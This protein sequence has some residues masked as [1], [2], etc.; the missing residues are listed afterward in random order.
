MFIE[1]K[2]FPEKK[3]MPTKLFKNNIIVKLPIIEEDEEDLDLITPEEGDDN[4][5]VEVVMLGP[6]CASKLEIGDNVIMRVRSFQDPKTGYIIGDDAY[7]MFSEADI[8]GA[9]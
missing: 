8:E 3:A 2:K 6:D 7:L 1:V 9:W 4:A 5:T